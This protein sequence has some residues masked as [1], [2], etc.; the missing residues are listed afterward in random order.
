MQPPPPLST[1]SCFLMKPSIQTCLCLL[2]RAICVCPASLMHPD[3]PHMCWPSVQC[4]GRRFS[5]MHISACDILDKEMGAMSICTYIML[6]WND[7][8]LGQCTRAVGLLTH[9]ELWGFLLS[10]LVTLFVPVLISVWLTF[11]SPDKLRKWLPF[12]TAIMWKFSEQ[13]L[14][15]TQLS[16]QWSDLHC[17]GRVDP[18]SQCTTLI[19]QVKWGKESKVRECPCC[20]QAAEPSGLSLPRLLKISFPSHCM[21]PLISSCSP[22]TSERKHIRLCYPVQERNRHWRQKLQQC[23]PC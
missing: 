19:Y 4:T 17:C 14:S 15:H 3:I 20:L 16:L 12:A 23:Y 7:H 9:Y 13:S 11:Q 10:S 6:T 8:T 5:E 21:I 18:N 22:L 2:Y 1:P